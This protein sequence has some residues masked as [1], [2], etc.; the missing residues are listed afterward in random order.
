MGMAAY[1]KVVLEE[2]GVETF[3][4]KYSY[5]T[6][7]TNLPLLNS[8]FTPIQAATLKANRVK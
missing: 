8:D 5:F 7:E 6:S 1:F 4:D 3:T 2:I